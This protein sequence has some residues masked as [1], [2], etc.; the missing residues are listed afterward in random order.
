MSF[1]YLNV[2]V[3]FPVCLHVILPVVDLQRYY[4]IYKELTA[5]NLR[6]ILFNFQQ[7][8]VAFGIP[9]H[10]ILLMNSNFIMAWTKMIPF[11]YCIEGCNRVQLSFEQG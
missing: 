11:L 7:D 2:K 9:S 10:T 8:F 4:E 3:F 1:D 6:D 5:I